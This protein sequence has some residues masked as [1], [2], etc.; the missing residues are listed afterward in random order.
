M[1]HDSE[2]FQP[3]PAAEMVNLIKMEDEGQQLVIKDHAISDCGLPSEG[4]AADPPI[5]S[6]TESDTES[7][8]ERFDNNGDAEGS[9]LGSW[10]K[11]EAKED[12]GDSEETPTMGE[13]DEAMEYDGVAMF[14]HLCFYLD[15]PKNARR[16]GMKVE[17]PYEAAISQK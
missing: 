2:E 8:P 1:G 14:R 5:T 11:V 3:L 17:N 10:E 4:S 15:S 13:N 6:E 7:E 9:S 16:H 12:N